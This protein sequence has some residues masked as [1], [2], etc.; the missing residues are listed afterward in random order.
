MRSLVRV[1][2]TFSPSTAR[3]LTRSSRSASWSGVTTH[4]P[5]G[6]V[7]L[8]RPTERELAAGGELEVAVADVLADLESG[9][10]GSC[11]GLVDASTRRRVGR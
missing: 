8:S 1:S 3:P 2:C 4:G 7:A 6:S 5:M 10:V 11:V 9:D